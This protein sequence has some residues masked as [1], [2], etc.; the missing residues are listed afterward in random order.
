MHILQKI[1][2]KHHNSLLNILPNVPLPNF[3]QL[4]HLLPEPSKRLPMIL[5][6]R[7]TQQP[8]IFLLNL[9][10]PVL[11]EIVGDIFMEVF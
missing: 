10:V 3:P 9:F 8:Q 1:I 11:V 4:L 6:I 5:M 7:R 2:K